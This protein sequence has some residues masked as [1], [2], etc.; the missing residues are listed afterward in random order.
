[1]ALKRIALR[2]FVIVEALEL[3]LHAGF[4]VLTGETGAGKSILIDALQLL[5]GGRADTGVI[6]E[7]SERTDMAAEF[8]APAA[9]APWLEEA[10]IPG[11]DSLLLRRTID[12]QGRSRAWING[13]PATATQMRAVGGQLLDIH[14]QHAWQSLT[15]QESVRGLLDAYA[16]V[17]AAPL[18][19]LWT[20]W[21]DARKALA[22]ARSAQDTLQQE[23]ERLQWQIGEVGK[24]A[25]GE[26]EWDELNAQHTR[27]SNAQALLDSAQGALAALEDEDGGALPRL[28][29]AQHLLQDYEQMDEAF[30]S[31]NEVLTS[32]L[33][34]AGD[35]VHSLQSYLRHTELDPE[36]LQEL[37][38]RLSQWMSLARR[39]KRTP[40]ELPALLQGWTAELQQLDTAADLAAL[41]A[42]E[43][44]AASA[45]AK[46]ARTLSQRRAKAAPKLAQAITQA[47]QGLGM[48]GGRFEVAVEPAAEPGPHGTDAIGF[49]VSSHP[50]MTPKPIGKV[51]SGGELSRIS[52]AISVTTSELGEAPTLIFDEVDSG[53]GGAV[54]ETVG[55][56]MQQLGR[57]RQ[58]LAVTHLP[59]VAAC[60]DHHLVVAKHKRA[61]GTTSSVQPAADEAR[62]KELARML[63]G[64]RLSATTLAHA[65]EMLDG[66]QQPPSHKG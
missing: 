43:Q 22:H 27:L 52:L 44:A 62:V 30:R 50:G 21:R 3:D 65:R 49:L 53:V 29:Q 26:D 66:A 55:R 36:R 39:Y 15:R 40:A 12:L 47:M 35:V 11:D 51:A 24:L 4:T 57:D 16:G 25:P 13:V 34:Q 9:L 54:A 58:V 31:M 61:G 63:G 41:E 33:A 6:R 60:A 19:G 64:E 42:A 59:Q 17:Q 37:D 2:D 8:D 23:R 10:G 32:C 38:A 7:G 56:L 46:A 28:A 14:G 20:T 1:M 48:T 5:L 45:Y 18:A